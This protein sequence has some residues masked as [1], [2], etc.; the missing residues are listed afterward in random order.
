MNLYCILLRQAKGYGTKR[1]PLDEAGFSHLVRRTGVQFFEVYALG[2]SFE[3]M[4]IC[5][6]PGNDSIRKLFEELEGWEITSAIVRDHLGRFGINSDQAS[7][8]HGAETVRLASSNRYTGI[9]QL[10]P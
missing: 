1:F 7:C 9:L 3:V 8:S 4:V 5:Q 10:L 6:A 2:G